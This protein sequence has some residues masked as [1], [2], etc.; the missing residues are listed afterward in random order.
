MTAVDVLELVIGDRVVVRVPNW[1]KVNRSGDFFKDWV[2]FPTE[3]EVVLT[4]VQDEYVEFD[5]WFSGTGS[6]L[7]RSQVVRVIPAPELFPGTSAALDA[8]TIRG[9]SA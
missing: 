2:G 5:H 4:D 7:P 1:R 6:M 8:L 3:H 9:E